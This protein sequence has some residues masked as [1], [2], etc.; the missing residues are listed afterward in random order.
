MNRADCGSQTRG[1]DRASLRRSGPWSQCATEK[2][3]RLSMNSLTP[4]LSP[5]G[6]EG[7][8]RPG[9]GASRDSREQC[10]F[11]VR[12]VLAPRGTS[13]ERAGERGSSAPHPAL[14]P[15]DGERFPRKISR[16]KPL[17]RS[18][19]CESAL[20]LASKTNKCADSRRRLRGSWG[21]EGR[22]RGQRNAVWVFL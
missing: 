8:R 19:R 4:S 21:G 9:E 14:S 2:S 12:D 18:R 13:G 5:T 10:A 3:W 22:V 17:N 20:I 16:I 11:E 1:P 6:G 15:S 7:G